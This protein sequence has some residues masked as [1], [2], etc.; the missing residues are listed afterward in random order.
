MGKEQK[1]CFS[2]YHSDSSFSGFITK[3]PLKSSL[4]QNES[5]S[6]TRNKNNTLTL[7]SNKNISKRNESWSNFGDNSFN[8]SSTTKHY[9]DSLV[10]CANDCKSAHQPKSVTFSDIV[11]KRV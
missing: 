7:E 9:L 5:W 10:C 1:L 2:T 3:K 8:A 11:I 4:R 6:D